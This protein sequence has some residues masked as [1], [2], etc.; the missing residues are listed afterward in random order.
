MAI[1]IH[2]SQPTAQTYRQAAERV[3]RLRAEECHSCLLAE[4]DFVV[5]RLCEGAKSPACERNR[6]F[7]NLVR[8]LV[9]VPLEEK[10]ASPLSPDAALTR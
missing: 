5:R 1:P 10:D 9:Y 3:R 8:L 6:R 4:R 2:G 7:L